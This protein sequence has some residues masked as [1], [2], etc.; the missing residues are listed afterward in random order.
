MTQGCQS[1]LDEALARAIYASGTPLSVTENRYWREAFKLL[2]PAFVPPSRHSLG[3]RL[4][5]AEY[6]RV[7]TL[8]EEKVNAALC[9][10]VLT[11]SWTNVRGESILNFVLATPKPI[12]Y[13]AVETEDHRHTGDYI[14]GEIVKVVEKIGTDKV[15]ALVTDHASNMKA[16][17]TIVSL[18]YPSITTLGC[19]AHGLNLLLSDMLKLVTLQEV[20]K[21]SKTVI[22]YVRN[23]H[24]VAAHF[25][26]RQEECYAGNQTTL[27]LPAETRWAG[28]L[29][30][31]EGLL[32]NK[33]ALQKTVIAAELQVS[34][35]IRS[36]ILDEDYF[37][38]DVQSTFHVLQPVARAISEAESDTAV[39]SDVH[40]IL[41]KVTRQV[42]EALPNSALTTGEKERV[43]EILRERRNFI[44]RPAH[45]AANLLDLKFK[46]RCLS[47]EEVCHAMDY[48]TE[49]AERMCLD[50]GKVLSNLAEYQVQSGAWSR[51]ALE[52]SAKHIPP[53]TWWQGL[54]A[55]EPLAPIACRLLQVPPSSAACERNWSKFSGVHTKSRNRLKGHR[56]QKLVFVR[57]NLE[58]RSPDLKYHDG[59]DSSVE[60][61]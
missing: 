13:S 22:K 42:E 21:R 53:S 52:D 25:A 24:V 6:A 47:D 28:I 36:T 43:A 10:T 60:S 55:S 40:E 7:L 2:R 11:D 35:E 18:R 16:A 3:E 32:K 48:I 8:V 4:L 19:C 26:K 50:V 1:K 34:R 37:W 15:F 38:R 56:V 61:E 46:G 39:L 49:T 20:C 9:V 41:F 45:A 33:E 17:W 23:S 54:C 44:C 30:S 29:M 58:L 57:S 27:K 59:D 51:K 12:F 14:A 5:E 31:L